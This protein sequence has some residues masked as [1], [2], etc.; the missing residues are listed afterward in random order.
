MA[1]PLRPLSSPELVHLLL[2]LLLLV[3]PIATT[4]RPLSQLCPDSGADFAANGTYSSNVNRLTS[5]LTTN[6]PAAG[7]LNATVGDFPERVYGFILCRGDKTAADCRSCLATAAVEI[8]QACPYKRTALVWYDNCMLKFSNLYFFSVSD[9]TWFGMRNQKFL[10]EDNGQFYT[11]LDALMKAVVRYAAYNASARMFGTGVAN[12]SDPE[13]PTIYALG[14]CTRDQ[15]PDDCSSCLTGIN[16]DIQTR[17]RW[18]RGARILKSTCNFRYELYLFYDGPS[19]VWVPLPRNATWRVLQAPAAAPL[20]PPTAQPAAQGKRKKKNQTGT[21]LAIAIPVGAALML[22]TVL[23]ICCSCHKQEKREKLNSQDITAIDSL[24]FSLSTLRTATCNFS[25]QNML[26][27][28]GFGSVYKGLLPNGQQIAVKRLSAGS[29]QGLGELKNEVLLLAKLQ[30]RNLVKLLGVCLEGDE[31]LLVYEYVPNRSLD[32]FLFDPAKTEQLGW[33][34]RQKIIGGIARGLLYLHEDS[35]LKII[36]RDLKA[37]NVLL[38]ATMNPKISDF[39]LARLVGGD[40]TQ[41]RTSRVVGTYGYMAPEYVMRGQ[42]SSKSDV[43]SFGVLVIEIVTGQRSTSFTTSGSSAD[44]LGRVWE[45]WRNG[46]VQEI[47]DPSLSGQFQGSELMRCIQIGLL[48]VQEAAADRPTMSSVVLMLCSESVS[49]RVP[50]RPAFCFGHSQ[51]AD[52]DGVGGNNNSS[53]RSTLEQSS[54][55]LMQELSSNDVTISELD[56]R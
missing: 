26:G 47:V 39:G 23:C 38:D 25:Q 36:H 35:Q 10:P 21:V 18:R 34:T 17:Y 44:L 51:P 11:Q 30:H 7:Y 29:S 55:R 28:G 2:G 16:D 20:P 4:A 31:K 32:T 49:M 13:N 6:G 53:A 22:A 5:I 24:L 46:T 27:Q 3:A 48:C 45:H 14:Q 37:S 42:F 41:A 52:P 50:S 1:L 8:L 56:P 43:F 15:T 33:E 9:S 19:M 54:S 40:Q 12:Y